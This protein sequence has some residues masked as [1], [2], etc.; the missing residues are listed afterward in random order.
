MQHRIITEEVPPITHRP[1]RLSPLESEHLKKELDKYRK[2][3]IIRPSHS[4]WAAPVILVKKKNGDYRLVID[5]RKLNAITK[6]DNYALLRIDDLLDAIGSAKHLSALDMKAGFHQ[7]PMDPKSIPFTAFTAKYGMWEYVT[8]PM[9]LCNSPSSFQRLVDL[10][11]RSLINRCVVAYVDDLNVYSNTLQEHLENLE[12]FQCVRVARLKF[13]PDKCHFFK[14][15]LEFLG[16]IVTAE[17]L[18]TDPAKVE[19]LKDFP[20]PRTITQIKSFL[21]MASYYRRFCGISTIGN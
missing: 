20:I 2:L 21:G 8:I 15:K 14:K 9:G 16:Y 4:P 5:Y 7:V 19:K 11:F 17:G 10:C 6:R 3:G 13:S 18:H 1:Y 12:D